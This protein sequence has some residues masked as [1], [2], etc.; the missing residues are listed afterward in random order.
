MKTETDIFSLKQVPWIKY[1]IKLLLSLLFIAPWIKYVSIRVSIYVF[2]SYASFESAKWLMCVCL[3]IESKEKEFLTRISIWASL[4]FLQSYSISESV[5]LDK[6]SCFGWKPSSE[7]KRDYF[8]FLEFLDE[9]KL[10][11]WFVFQILQAWVVISKTYLLINFQFQNR[12]NDW[13]EKKK[14][15]INHW[16]FWILVA[17]IKHIHL[18]PLLLCL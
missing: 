2:A 17:H 6:E 18:H 16:I 8:G 15:E 4:W 5:E 10:E 1:V 13:K 7:L 12:K 3:I 9:E 14:L 11:K